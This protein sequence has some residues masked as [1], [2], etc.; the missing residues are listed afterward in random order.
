MPTLELTKG[1][2]YLGEV[3]HINEHVSSF[4]KQAGGTS[5]CHIIG[6]TLPQYNGAH[7]STQICLNFETVDMFGIG[8]T[9]KFVAHLFTKGQWTIKFVEKML[10]PTRTMP[11]AIQTTHPDQL[12]DE[13][14]RNPYIIGSLADRSMGHACHLLQMQTLNKETLK[15]Y[16]DTIYEW[17]K[18]RMG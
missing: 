5:Y 2:T 1:L 10:K 4:S 15:D 16:A 18:E 9:I 17:M 14:K 13:P 11:A 8:D 12:P 3:I 7:I 6:M